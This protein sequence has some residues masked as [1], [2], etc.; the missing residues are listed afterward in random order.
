MS[1]TDKS[2]WV[3]RVLG[4]D[5]SRVRSAGPKEKLLPIWIDAKEKADVGITRLQDA[6]RSRDDDD[7]GS[8]AEFGLYGATTGQAVG[9][10]AAL[11]DADAS[12]KPEAY[13]RVKKAV[14]DYLD[15]MEGAPIFDLI[16]DNPFGVQVPI[17]ATLR[18]ALQRLSQLAAA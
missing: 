7:L 4:V 2:G 1:D 18:P 5:V 15:F 8:I 6:L 3:L 16:E 9:L 10:M 14:D 13:S 17:R 12:G 11:R